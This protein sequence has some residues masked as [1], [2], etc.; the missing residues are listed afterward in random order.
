MGAI[1]WCPHN[2]N[3]DPP[4]QLKIFSKMWPSLLL[5]KNIQIVTPPTLTPPKNVQ[6][7]EPRQKNVPPK[8]TLPQKWIILQF[9]SVDEVERHAEQEHKK[10]QILPTGGHVGPQPRVGR[11]QILRVNMAQRRVNPRANGRQKL[12]VN[13]VQRRVNRVPQGGHFGGCVCT[14]SSTGS[15]QQK[16]KNVMVGLFSMQ[17]TQKAHI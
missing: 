3:Y 5:K 10:G 7:C 14:K 13:I 2:L 17:E 12:R 11:R 1:K 16:L 4:S 6:N 9:L 15:V 8:F